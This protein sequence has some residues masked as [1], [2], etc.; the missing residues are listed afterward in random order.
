MD[1]NANR[2][3]GN[4]APGADAYWQRRFFTLIAG[5]AVVGLLAW[6]VSGVASGGNSSKS[7][8]SSG[9]AAAAYA[10][11]TAGTPSPSAP[12]TSAAASP[13]PSPS[14]SPSSSASLSASASKSASAKAHPA[15]AA[16]GPATCPAAD[17]VLTLTASQASYGAKATPSFQVDIV[18]TDSA[19]CTLD[20][21]PEALKLV[22]THGSTV[23]YD[24]TTCLQGAPRH[25][26]SLRRGVPV[27]T[28]LSWN[29][30]E[31]VSGCSATVM[32]A[33]NRTYAAVAQAGGA[34]SPQASFNLAA[35][36]ATTSARNAPAKQTSGRGPASA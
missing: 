35:T 3:R 6:A 2:S 32:A 27:V 5:L 24:S 10:S 22:V 9:P 20:T 21:G 11:T 30:H 17:L 16:S 13:S 14:A 33:A 31:T 7:S 26:I 36:P 25:V 18:S 29:E 8:G 12:V 23:A 19:T 4:R 1:P 34:Q 28:S 15:N